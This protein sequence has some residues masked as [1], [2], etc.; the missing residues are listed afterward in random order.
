MTESRTV[1]CEQK[2]SSGGVV[3]SVWVLPG[4]LSPSEADHYFKYGSEE[5]DLETE[6]LV[7]IFGR[8]CVCHRRVGFF[9]QTSSGYAFAGQIS[10]TRGYPDGIRDLTLRVND[11]IKTDFD[12]IL[13]NHYRDGS[14]NIGAHSDDERGL[15]HGTVAVVSV[16]ATRVLRIRTKSDKKRLIDIPMPHG[17]LLVMEGKAQKIWTH[18]VP[19]AKKIKEG[20]VSY[21]LRCHIDD[22]S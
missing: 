14:D 17:S 22:L 8:D 4:F 12:S 2:N 6:P 1:Y 19:T 13:V 9:S 11:Y 10:R 18:E 15:S 3:A 20:R 5:L 16:G 21:T 7:K